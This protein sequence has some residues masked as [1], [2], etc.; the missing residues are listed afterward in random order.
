LP[1]LEAAPSKRLRRA[2][3]PGESPE[4]PDFYFPTLVITITE[5]MFDA[6]TGF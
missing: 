5:M 4:I 2:S 1:E 6:P 3:S